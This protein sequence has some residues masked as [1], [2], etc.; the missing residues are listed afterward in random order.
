M[1]SHGCGRL[2]QGQ[3]IPRGQLPVAGGLPRG[4]RVSALSTAS[5]HLGGLS[6]LFQA[7]HCLSFIVVSQESVRLTP[8]SV[9]D[10]TFLIFLG[11]SCSPEKELITRTGVAS[12]QDLALLIHK[13][14]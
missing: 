1:E 11:H 4:L 2:R 9:N 12:R 8:S 5:V 3:R 7:P 14:G 13:L 10:M 6:S